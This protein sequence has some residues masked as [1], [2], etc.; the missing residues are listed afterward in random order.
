M[1]MGKLMRN[2]TLKYVVGRFVHCDGLKIKLYPICL[3]E[4]HWEIYKFSD[5][6]DFRKISPRPVF[7]FRPDSMLFPKCN[8]LQPIIFR[9]TV[10][11][12]IEQPSKL[13]FVSQ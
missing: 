7:H 5:H 12:L 6:P 11:G 1:G 8:D 13:C 10:K 9:Q 4:S 3:S 2:H